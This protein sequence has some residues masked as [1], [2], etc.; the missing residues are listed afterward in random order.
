MKSTVPLVSKPKNQNLW[1]QMQKLSHLF[2]D[3]TFPVPG[4]FGTAKLYCPQDF[5]EY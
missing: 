3:L 5:V 4:N 1:K 2:D